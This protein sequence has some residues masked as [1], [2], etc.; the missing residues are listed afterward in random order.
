MQRKEALI[1][2]YQP[3]TAGYDEMC[4][5]DGEVRPHW[6]Y[7]ARVLAGLN[8]GELDQRRAEADRLLRENGVTYNVYSDPAGGQRPWPLD[9]IPLLIPSEEWRRIESGLTQRAEVLNLLLRDIYGPRDLIR[10]GL[11]PY[12]LV[13]GHPGFLRPCA[14]MAGQKPHALILY[15]ADLA[16]GPD[17]RMWVLSDRTQAPSGTGYA[18]ENRT[19]M[20]QVFPSLYRDSHVHRLAVFFQAL[21]AGLA[22]YA[23]EGSDAPRV[24]ILTPGPLNET[25]FEH[26]YL[27]NY[28]G[29]SLVR[30]DDLM[31]RDGR[32][33]L[34][35]LKRLEPVDVIWR[36]VDDNY[37]DPLE[38]LPDSDLGVPGLV[39]AVR[40]G[41]VAVVNPLGA[42]ILENPA[43]NAF[44]PGI[45]QYFLGQPL[46]L[47]TV[48]TWWCGKVR[49]RRHVTA[50]L[51]RMVVRMIHR[52]F[53]SR[54]IY[55]ALLSREERREIA[56]R[57]QM[58]PHLY[59]GQ[60]QIRFSCAP[61]LVEG[62][63]AAHH[64]VLRAF[65]IARDDGYVVMPGGLTRVA[66]SEDNL[67]VSNQA[68]G[69][70]KDTW[71]IASEPEKQV[72]LLPAA[73]A[74]ATISTQQ[75]SLP[76]RAADN[77][78]WFARYAERA[79]QS[80]RLM[81]TVLAAHH[82]STR[83]EEPHHQE[84]FEALRQTLGHVTG[85]SSGAI[86]LQTGV[87]VAGSGSEL[88][89]IL[90]DSQLRG[91]IAFNLRVMLEAAQGVRDPLSSDAR[92]LVNDLRERLANL[93]HL[94]LD[95]L[96][97]A[98]EHLNQ[99]V[100]ALAGLSGLVMESMFRGEAWLFWEI[101]RRL[102][103][104]LLL[105]SLLRGAL[106]WTRPLP[107][108]RNVVEAVLRTC[109]SLVA[110]R[111]LH[112][113]APEIVPTLGL[114]L[115]DETSPRSLKF[116]LSRLEKHTAAL[117]RE[118]RDTPDTDDAA[119]SEEARC[120]LEAAA[121]MRLIDLAPLVTADRATG[122]REALDVFF[123]QVERLLRATSEALSRDYFTDARGLRQLLRTE[124]PT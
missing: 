118:T 79:E 59:V 3:Y 25:Y 42:S 31:V 78:F 41:H 40:Q 49:E 82:S 62:K 37:C 92:Q 21:R 89:A 46:E 114:L 56:R 61:T 71:I 77:L 91:G 58:H 83:L 48:A 19:V 68:G 93:E 80:M 57:I 117:P 45:A 100:T 30:G 65:L 106:V 5:P 103:R 74:A 96:L 84:T 108:E 50:N 116:Q 18:L 81:R 63:L 85:L 76:P 15:A 73:P 102:E 27:A 53:G 6:A 36:R 101:G 43:L 115:L 28:L 66:S 16:R 8:R 44:L 35:S 2:Q 88:H 64:A 111:R 26:A 10:R 14:P 110:Y 11:L 60:E 7:L 4:A 119:V 47:P 112:N 86:G 39:E 29:Y 22:G 98:E 94:S 38:L 72:S 122:R 97:E 121:A 33:W 124:S 109:D 75:P 13:Y 23:P 107:V 95:Q 17:G 87:P 70:A 20:S 120:V 52:R 24:V 32:V 104:G 1:P 9:L 12:E 113:G 105:V 67:I 55:G 99:L 123:R 34:R 90:S 51:D 54:P 69:I